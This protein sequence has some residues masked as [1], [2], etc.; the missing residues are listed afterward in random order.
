MSSLTPIEKKDATVKALAL[1]VSD[2]VPISC[3]SSKKSACNLKDMH[4]EAFA[5][6]QL[7]RRFDPCTTHLRDPTPTELDEEFA[8]L[9]KRQL[10]DPKAMILF[11]YSGHAIEDKGKLYAITEGEQKSGIYSIEDKLTELGQ[12][13]LVHAFFNCNR[14]YADYKQQV[15][16]AQYVVQKK[17]NSGTLAAFVYATRTGQRVKSLQSAESYI[18][19]L[20]KHMKG[21]QLLFPHVLRF[22][23]GYGSMDM[24]TSTKKNVDVLY[25]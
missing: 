7:Y 22:F 24:L 15:A 6:A 3:C 13:T 23:K 9:K 14:I 4:V 8:K 2:E 20:Q 21:D 12:K 18:S 25:T 19:H 17:I 16:Q 11:S 5:I 10:A 1:V